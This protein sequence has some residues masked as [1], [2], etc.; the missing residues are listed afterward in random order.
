MGLSLII[1]Y[2]FLEYVRPQSFFPGLAVLHIPMFVQI[3]IILHLSRCSLHNLKSK[4][5]IAFLLLICLMIFHIPFATNNYSAYMATRTMTLQ[6]VIFLAIVGFLKSFRNFTTALTFWVTIA[7]LSGAKGYLE[8]GKI[9]GS[10]F[11]GDEN[12][13]SLFMNMMI[14]LAFFKGQCARKKSEKFIWYG[15]VVILILG[16]VSSMSRGGFLGLLPPLAFCWWKT[17]HKVKTGLAAS[18][19]AL[20]LLTSVVP[21]SYWNEMRTITE[22]GI[23]KGTGSHRVYM[24]KRA[25]AMFL[26]N[27]L[28]GVGPDN[29]RWNF[30]DYEPYGGHKGRSEAGRAVHSIYFTLVPELGLVG[31][32]LFLGMIWVNLKD[33]SRLRRLKETLRGTHPRADEETWNK[34]RNMEALGWGLMGAIIAYLISG[35]FLSVLYYGHFWLIIGFSVARNNIVRDLLAE[36]EKAP[37]VPFAESE[38]LIDAEPHSA[39]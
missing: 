10:A 30:K 14:P 35:A 16:T 24:W 11:L 37:A 36:V 4:E 27:P 34:I 7:I 18:G 29:V 1:L 21:D 28:V 39:T 26:D 19:I 12:D 6:F 38:R 9:P 22:E 25:W 2:M 17:P 3:I 20:I 8:G 33:R 13:F 23:T 31:T 32:F 15:G 5:T